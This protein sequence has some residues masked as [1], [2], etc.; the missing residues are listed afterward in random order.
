MPLQTVKSHLVWNA[1]NVRP[2]QTA[3]VAPTANKTCS[4][5]TIRMI[6]YNE[7]WN[8]KY[9]RNLLRTVSDGTRAVNVPSM[10]V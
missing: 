3:A 2:R 1:N 8:G 5:Q 7:I 4:I 6:D 10:N 9:E